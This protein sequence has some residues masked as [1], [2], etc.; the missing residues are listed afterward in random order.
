M[1]MRAN[2][3]ELLL[4]NVSKKY[5][6]KLAL[7]HFNFTFQN[8]IC[9][10]LGPNGAGKSTMMNLIVGNLLPESGG[11]ILWNGESTVRL[12]GKFRE[13]L[14]FMPQQ[15][16]LYDGFTAVRFMSYIAALKGLSKEEA[17]RRIPD[18]LGKV[19][20]SDSAGK[21]IG[22]FSGGMKQRLL[23]AQALL[24]DPKLLLLDE[25]TAGL[26]PKQRV[27]IRR[28]IQSLTRDRVILIS[29]HIVSDV[30][31]IADQVIFLNHGKMIAH[32][33]LS[34]VCGGR[35]LEQAYMGY[36]GDENDS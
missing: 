2:M 9:A 1:N 29:T 24:G 28:L 25:P 35:T 13:N 11:E 26:D 14:G 15:Q 7:D 32:G 3:S 12:G 4:K 17:K 27:I 30:E 10:L 6:E 33:G 31:S 20:L 19:E 8:G 21:K 18:L 16:G 22:G 36:F 5:R 34:E 23:I